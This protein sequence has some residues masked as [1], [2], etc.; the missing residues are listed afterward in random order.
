MGPTAVSETS[1]S[2]PRTG[3]KNPNTKN[4]YSF[5]G[6][7]LKSRKKKDSYIFRIEKK[8]KKK[9]AHKFS[10]LRCLGFIE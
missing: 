5:H 10:E 6:E 2:L 9:K 8:E 3:C 7:S 1:G 4:Q